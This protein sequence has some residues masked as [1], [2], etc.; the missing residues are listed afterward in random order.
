LGVGEVRS[1]EDVPTELVVEWAEVV[2]E[3]VSD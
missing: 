3:P 2:W 1:Q